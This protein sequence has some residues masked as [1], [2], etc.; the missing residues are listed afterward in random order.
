MAKKYTSDQ[1]KEIT[2]LAVEEALKAQDENDDD[3][4][5]IKS[6]DELK[7]RIKEME[8][9]IQDFKNKFKV[10]IE[11][12]KNDEVGEDDK[13]LKDKIQSSISKLFK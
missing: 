13:E 11:N 3:D 5:K 8:S 1:V 12:T 9:Q 2:A 6:N 10:K 7:N 4:D